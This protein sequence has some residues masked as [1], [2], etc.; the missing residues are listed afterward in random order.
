MSKLNVLLANEAG[1]G[2]GHISL[3]A[4]VARALGPDLDIHAAVP[5]L[6]HAE[7]LAP[8]KVERGPLLRYTPEARQHNILTGNA[9]WGDYLAACGLTSPEIVRAHLRW[10]RRK[11]IQSDA[12]ILVAD[13]A[14]LALWAARGLKGEGWEIEILSVGTGY[15]LP[16]A[17]MTEFPQ[18][19]PDFDRRAITEEQ[20]LVVLNT[21]ALS[22]GLEPL[23]RFPEISQADREIAFTFDYLDPY[24]NWREDGERFVPVLSP[25]AP[26]HPDSG[27]E[28]FIYFSRRELDDPAL[29]EAVEELSVPRRGFFPGAPSETLDRLREAGVVVETRPLPMSEIAA[30]ARLV[31]SAGQHGLQCMT[32][33]AGLP[34]VA[35]PQHLEQVFNC[36]RSEA[37]GGTRH[38][39]LGTQT[40]EAIKDAVLDAWSDT[41]LRKTARTIAMELRA[42]Y[43]ADPI[44]TLAATLAPLVERAQQAF[45]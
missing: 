21:V 30:R 25:L 39:P 41:S 32:A 45:R 15:G 43:P 26:L 22:E 33:L 14:P 20:T 23:H 1:G 2:R 4:G 6:R 13:Y 8:A 5:S 18:L 10:W 7:E 12:S 17:R 3:L 31:L 16:P 27:T 19:L 40:R 35:V 42:H 37:R 29:I 38:V 28:L 11:I 44:S 9:T 24:S 36:R 34:H